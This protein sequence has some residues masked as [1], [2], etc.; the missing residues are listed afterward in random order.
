MKAML[1]A[2][3]YLFGPV[4]LTPNIG[5]ITLVFGEAGRRRGGGGRRGEGG[6]G[7]GRG[8]RRGGGGGGG[9][10]GMEGRIHQPAQK[11]CD[12]LYQEPY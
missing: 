2:S 8:G 11:A 7:G 9:G 4:P 3:G 5:L 1:L 12:C 6:R 10:E